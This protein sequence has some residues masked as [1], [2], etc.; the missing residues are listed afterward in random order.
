MPVAHSCNPSYSGDRDQEDGVLK[1]AHANSSMRPYLE[2]TL[3]RKGL[4]VWLKVKVLSSSP[5]TAK[6][7]KPKK[8]KKKGRD[9]D[10]PDSNSLGIKLNSMHCKQTFSLILGLCTVDHS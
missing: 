5:S 7:N 8:K 3:H 9:V 1:P 4:V 2:K 6:I 10:L